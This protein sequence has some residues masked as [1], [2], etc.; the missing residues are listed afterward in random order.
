M[1]TWLLYRE[2]SI[3]WK[4]YTKRP[5]LTETRWR[6]VQMVQFFLDSVI[7]LTIGIKF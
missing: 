5:A 4:G 1:P 2:K 3:G 7:K 6:A